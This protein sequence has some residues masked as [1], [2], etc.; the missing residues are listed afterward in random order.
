MATNNHMIQS[1]LGCLKSTLQTQLTTL[2]FSFSQVFLDKSR[3]QPNYLFRLSHYPSP[4]FNIDC[5]IFSLPWLTNLNDMKVSL[6]ISHTASNWFHRN[7]FNMKTLKKHVY[8]PT[9]I[10][11][12]SY[13]LK[14][15][16]QRVSEIIFSIYYKIYMHLYVCMYVNSISCV[17]I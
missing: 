8:K 16:N 5:V 4:I 11:F 15:A 2:Q 3:K 13:A 12:K 7:K 9:V 14:E 17:C 10:L 6:D 1:I